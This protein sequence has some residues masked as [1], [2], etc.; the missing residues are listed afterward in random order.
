M[1]GILWLASIVIVPALWVMV[2]RK[3]GDLPLD[4]GQPRWAKELNV[5]IFISCFTIGANVIHILFFGRHT[6]ASVCEI[7]V[8]TIMWAV[9]YVINMKSDL[10]STRY[11]IV[12][13]A[14]IQVATMFVLR[15]CVY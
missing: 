11:D 3:S 14:A 12:V 7:V 6:A 8:F 1:I 4:E 15:S 5:I 2:T 13:V 10:D 9:V